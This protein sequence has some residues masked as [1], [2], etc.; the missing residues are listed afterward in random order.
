MSEES[1]ATE[2]TPTQEAPTTQDSTAVVDKPTE[3]DPQQQE[4]T[5][6]EKATAEPEA[7]KSA[8][9]T[10]EETSKEETAEPEG[11]PEQYEFTVPE[12]FPEGFALNKDVEGALGE[13]ARA[14][15][16][17]QDGAQSL[18]DKVFPVMRRVSLAEDHALNEQWLKETQADPEIGGAD[19][20]KNMAKAQRT[21]LAYGSEGLVSLLKGHPIGSNPELLRML[22]KVGA[23]VSEDEFV[24]GDPAKKTVDLNDVDAIAESWYGKGQGSS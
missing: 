15:G 4:Q 17:S 8:L 23:T 24:D 11:P 18:V 9:A 16:L 13:A 3:S 10:E 19:F 5:T 2:I 1:V 7:V 22:V 12:G 6:E 21:L 14:L 20:E